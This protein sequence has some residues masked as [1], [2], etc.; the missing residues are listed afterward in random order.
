[1]AYPEDPIRNLP[2]GT[3]IDSSDSVA[4]YVDSVL[5][6]VNV[7]DLRPLLEAAN[8][9][10]KTDF[11]D[12]GSGVNTTNKF[13]GRMV[14]DTTS[15]LYL[16]T[17]SEDP[18]EPWYDLRGMV[19]YV[20]GAP[21]TASVKRVYW[22]G[23]SFSHCGLNHGCDGPR[24]GQW[25][26]A[27]MASHGDVLLH[28]GQVGLGTDAFKDIAEA[29]AAGDG[30]WSNS[31]PDQTY[32]YGILGWS[33][34]SGFAF[35]DEVSNNGIDALT[36]ME[37]FCDNVLCLQYPEYPPDIPWFEE[38]LEETPSEWETFRSA[39]AAN[40]QAAGFTIID[41]TSGW[42]PTN[43]DLPQY[44]GYGDYHISSQSSKEIAVRVFR[45][46]VDNYA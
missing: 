27:L 32:D 39:Y 30:G 46:L 20:P 41:F 37:T 1:M 8:Q 23:S 17:K 19:K 2:Q 12:E 29:D 5:S 9:A 3:S 35:I 26:G 36:A 7:S 43:Q 22:L 33:G 4:V 16:Y 13:A 15:E 25:L 21:T 10:A 24:I 6:Y 14:Y 31:Y 18:Y 45:W 40:I 38:Y 28:R 11:E 44:L 34:A 42:V